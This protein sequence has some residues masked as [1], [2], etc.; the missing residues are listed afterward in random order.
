LRPSKVRVGGFESVNNPH[1]ADFRRARNR[2][3]RKDGFYDV[4]EIYVFSQFA[5]DGRDEMVKRRVRFQFAE[6]FDR[7]RTEP[8]NSADVVSQKVNNHRV[9]SQIFFRI[10]QFPFQL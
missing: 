6:F 9:F 5:A 2:A 7:D 1:R 4:G 8:A 3:A 10:Q